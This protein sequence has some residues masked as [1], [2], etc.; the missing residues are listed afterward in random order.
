ML[1]KVKRGNKIGV[2]HEHQSQGGL[3]VLARIIAGDIVRKRIASVKKLN[4]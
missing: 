3:L 1:K 2:G 4:E